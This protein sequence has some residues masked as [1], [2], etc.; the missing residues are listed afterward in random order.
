MRVSNDLNVQVY[1]KT[2]M[3]EFMW[4]SLNNKIKKMYLVL[5][6]WK[7]CYFQIEVNKLIKYKYTVFINFIRDK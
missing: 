7:N 5:L 2:L 3:F 1:G 4:I 6:I